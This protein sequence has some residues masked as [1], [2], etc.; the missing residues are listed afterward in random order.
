[1][2]IVLFTIENRIA[3][4]TLNHSEKHN[5]L[6]S[7]MI[8]ALFDAYQ[9]ADEHPD[10]DVIMLQANGKHFCAGADLHYMLAMGNASWE[11][12]FSD[13]K[14]FAQLFYAIYHCK[15]STIACVHGN[16]RGGGIGLL[17]A[18]D[19]AIAH[20]DSTFAFSEVT[21]GLVPAIISPY[22]VRRS[23]PQDAHYFM[24]TADIFNAPIAQKI[25][26]LDQHSPSPRNEATILAKTLQKNNAIAIQQTKHWLHTFLPI[27]EEKVTATATLLA[28]MR[29]SDTAKN[30][31]TS[32]L[33]THS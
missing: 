30:C 24:L 29:A 27:T 11:M 22:V 10:I 33:K 25:K 9:T 21:L 20:T 13:A 15:K 26:L 28:T 12:N 14:Q 19:F 8:N 3:T 16:V 5:I 1:M 4:I 2:S 6:N 17:A 32:Y 7:L 31:I 23:S 18:H